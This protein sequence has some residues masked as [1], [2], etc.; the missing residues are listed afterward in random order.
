MPDWNPASHGDLIRAGRTVDTSHLVVS[1]GMTRDLPCVG[2]TRGR[3]RKSRGPPRREQFGAYRLVQA[4]AGAQCDGR[5]VAVELVERHSGGQPE[6]ERR[7]LLFPCPADATG[8]VQVGPE[9]DEDFTVQVGGE[10]L[11]PTRLAK[12]DLVKPSA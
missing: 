6:R 4:G 1:K 8:K 11:G 5:Y 10:V 12:H 9:F 3:E 2:M 7:V